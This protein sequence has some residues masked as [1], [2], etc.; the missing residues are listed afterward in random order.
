M[1]E[2]FAFMYVCAPHVCSAC[3]GQMKALDRLEMQLQTAVS[4]HMGAGN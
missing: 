2:G 4:H 3:E 1:Y